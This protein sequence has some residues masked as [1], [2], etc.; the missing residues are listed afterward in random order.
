MKESV[1]RLATGKHTAQGAM[2]Q[3]Y[4]PPNGT[5]IDKNFKKYDLEDYFDNLSSAATTEKAVL[6]QLTQA[7]ATLTM[8]SSTL[9]TSDDK[10][11]AEVANLT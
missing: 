8:N 10:L 7:I 1:R 2:C 9:V 4:T 11:M 6:E 3:S 5:V